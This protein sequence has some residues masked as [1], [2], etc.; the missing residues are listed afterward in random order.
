MFDLANVAFVETALL[1]YRQDRERAERLLSARTRL[2]RTLE[3]ARLRYR[4]G[5][6]SLTDVLDVQRQVSALDDRL[7][8]AEAVVIIDAV[9]LD[10]AL[11]GGW[12]VATVAQ[13]DAGAATR[14]QR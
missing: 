8:Q 7:A 2:T 14:V 9:S 4:A 10:K 3:L 12:Q 5:E 13:A 6:A 11:G 1:R